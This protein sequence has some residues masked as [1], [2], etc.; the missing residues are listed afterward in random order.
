MRV[1]KDYCVHCGKELDRMKDYGC[2]EITVLTFFTTDLCAECIK[3]L[4]NIALEFCK[5]KGGEEV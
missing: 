3:K 1:T 2:T 5:K 4:D